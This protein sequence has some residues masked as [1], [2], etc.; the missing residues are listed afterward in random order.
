LEGREVSEARAK[1]TFRRG[2]EKELYSSFGTKELLEYAAK[3]IEARAK[4]D[5]PKRGAGARSSWNS[6]RNQIESTV[7]MDKNGW[8]AGV[9]TEANDRVRHAMLLE[10]GFTDRGG[11]RHPGRRWLKGALLKARID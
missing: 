8:Y 6:I 10:K 3:R 4:G 1:V 11:R 7:A 9:Y 2:W 5:S